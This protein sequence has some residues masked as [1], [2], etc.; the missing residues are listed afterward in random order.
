MSLT[1]KNMLLGVAICLTGSVQAGDAADLKTKLTSIASLKANF[2]QTVT[3]I[4]GKVIQEGSGLFALQQPNQFYWH[5]LLPDESLIVADGKDVWVYNPFAEEVTVMGIND[6]I[7][8]SPISLLVNQDE[9]T[10]SQYLV[11]QTASKQD[12]MACYLIQPNVEQ[13]EGDGTQSQDIAKTQVSVCFNG[14]SLTEFAILDEQ[15]NYSQFALSDQA[16]VS[17]EQ[18]GLFNFVIP[19]DVDVDDQRVVPEG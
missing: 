4:N 5:L 1:F 13:Q 17:T 6:A 12:E 3:D 16:E 7:L 11:T 15:G 9:E 8:A 2:E 10:W 19:D 18:A 14:L